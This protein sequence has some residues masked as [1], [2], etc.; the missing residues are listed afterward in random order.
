MVGRPGCAPVPGRTRAPWCD[1]VIRRSEATPSNRSASS[2]ISPRASP[3]SLSAAS[4]LALASI[5]VQPG[6]TGRTNST[7]NCAVSAAPPAGR[8]VTTALPQQASAAMANA[9]GSKPPDGDARCDDAGSRTTAA[10]AAAWRKARPRVRYAGMGSPSRPS[11]RR[12]P[13]SSSGTAMAIFSS[14]TI[15]ATI[16]ITY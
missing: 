13:A 16:K 6:G 15:V 7:R 11:P 2:T 10:P 5:Q 14:G 8:A 4:V 3:P 1:A 12:S 9:P